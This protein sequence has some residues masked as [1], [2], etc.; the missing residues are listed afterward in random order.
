[1]REMASL[2]IPELT[3]KIRNHPDYI[4]KYKKLQEFEKDRKFCG[5]L[6]DHFFAV[7]RLMW[8]YNLEDSAGLSKD[9]IY[10][11]AFLHDMGRCD[12]YEKKIP[13][14]IAGADFA[15]NIMTEV[16]FSKEDANAV[17]DAILSHRSKDELD[18][19]GLEYYLNKADKKSRDCLYCKVK[20][21]CN[22]PLEKKNMI[23]EY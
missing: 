11:A 15:F 7:A 5:H 1:M 17:K 20:D 16:G 21:E 4:E 6:S 13:H 23:I 10:A 22:W 2:I 9:L 3:N 8:I 14:D 12:E 18:T 19:K